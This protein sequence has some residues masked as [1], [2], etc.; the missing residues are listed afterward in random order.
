MKIISNRHYKYLLDE[1][2][3]LNETNARNIKFITSIEIPA[4]DFVNVELKPKEE[5]I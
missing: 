5:I 2:K 3:S 4:M 1:I